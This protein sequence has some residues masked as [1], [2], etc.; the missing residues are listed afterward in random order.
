MP[1]CRRKLTPACLVA[2]AKIEEADNERANSE[3]AL[4]EVENLRDEL[5]K[6]LDAI[7]ER[8]A[9]HRKQLSAWHVRLW[10]CLT[11]QWLMAA[12][13]IRSAM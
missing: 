12:C 5:R 1:L 3:E 4:A 11:R 6:E 8:T 13:R 10:L 9:E 2:Q 7:K